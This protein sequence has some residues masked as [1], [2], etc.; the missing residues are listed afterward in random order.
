MMVSEIDME[1][2]YGQDLETPWEWSGLL[3]DAML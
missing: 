3:R 1:S 2:S